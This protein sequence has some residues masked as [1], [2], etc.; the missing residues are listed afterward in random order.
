M[1]VHGINYRIFKKRFN[2]NGREMF[3][4]RMKENEKK[5]EETLHKKVLADPEAHGLRGSLS[6]G[7][8]KDRMLEL[9]REYETKEADRLKQSPGNENNL[10]KAGNEKMGKTPWTDEQRKNF[11]E[12]MVR[13]REAKKEKDRQYHRRK[14]R[15][16]KALPPEVL[17]AEEPQPP[18]NGSGLHVHCMACGFRMEIS[19][20]GIK[21][22]Q[23]GLTK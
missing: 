19:P 18:I 5:Q 17:T 1:A 15:E 12:A 3:N 4:N 23:K 21:A 20:E 6:D 2:E 8:N 7:I 14:A 22:L 10:K 13:K 16:K 9:A 11:K